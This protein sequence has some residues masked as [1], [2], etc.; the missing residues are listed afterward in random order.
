MMAI[1]ESLR[2]KNVVNIPME[3]KELPLE[4]MVNDGTL[5]VLEAGRYDL[6]TPF[7]GQTR[8]R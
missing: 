2:I 3:T 1:Y 7:E 6:R 8:N 4:L 5:P